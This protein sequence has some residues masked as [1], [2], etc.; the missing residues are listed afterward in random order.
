MGSYEITF[1]M[2]FLM[3]VKK[4]QINFRCSEAIIFKKNCQY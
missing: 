3:N 2:E 4:P 1:K